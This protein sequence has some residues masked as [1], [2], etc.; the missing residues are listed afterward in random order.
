MGSPRGGIAGIGMTSARTRD[1]LVQRLRAHGIRS[2]AVLNQV[3]SVPRHLF[4]DEA[5]ASRAYEDTALPIGLGQTISQPWVVAR[6]TEA[7]LDG[8][9][10]ETVLEIGTGW[11]GFAI[12][13]AREYGARVTTTTISREQRDLAVKRI[14]EAGALSCVDGV[15]FAPHRRVD[16]AA[17]GA[18]VRIG[19]ESYRVIGVMESKGQMLGFDLDDP[20][21][22]PVARAMKIFNLDELGEIDLI[23]TNSQVLGQ[24][25]EAEALKAE[26]LE[27]DV[28]ERD[29]AFP[30]VWMVDKEG[31]LTRL[32]VAQLERPVAAWIDEGTPQEGE[33]VYAAKLSVDDLQID[34]SLP[35]EQVHRV[36]RV[37]A[38]WTT[39][40]GARLKVLAA[41]LVDGTVYP[42][43]VQPEGRAAMPFEAWSN[44]A[45]P[46]PG[47]LFGDL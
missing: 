27:L 1:R 3:R 15:A 46:Q 34:W 10:G 4:V 23:F 36:I 8:F 2:E 19:G 13:A 38:A 31:Q 45:R 20:A 6:M 35:P 14:R 44:G 16:V 22:I 47:E 12:H 11:G 29:G 5:L 25:E 40:R 33:P 24:V 7:L 9:T 32:L 30:Y 17:L 39:F 37:G 43:T 26:F 28:D 42:V 18:R 21:F 41:R